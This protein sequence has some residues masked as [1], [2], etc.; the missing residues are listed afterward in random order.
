MGTKKRFGALVVAIAL[1]AS[2]CGGGSEVEAEQA[3]LL[4]EL[5]AQVDELT[6]QAD[7]AEQPAAEPAPEPSTTTTEAVVE[8]EAPVEPAEPE[9]AEEAAVEPDKESV[10]ADEPAAELADDAPP[11]PVSGDV[12]N[13]SMGPC[14]LYTS[15]S[16]RDRQKSRMPSSA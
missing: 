15:P 9:P 13:S 14:L 6:A 16:P 4:E 2:A 1:I 7:A 12:I 3:A 11:A 5:E 8:E 10:A